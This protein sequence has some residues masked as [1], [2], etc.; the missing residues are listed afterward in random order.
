MSGSQELSRRTLAPA[1]PGINFQTYWFYERTRG[2]YQNEK[3]KLTPAKQKK[4]E[5]MY[6]RGQVIDKT[7]AAKYEVTWG[8]QPHLVSSG[9]QKNFVAFANLVAAKWESAPDSF[10]ELYWKHLVA[11][12]LLFE[13]VRAAIAKADW[14]QKGYLANCVTYTLAKLAYEIGRQSR[15][16]SLDLD[17]IWSTQAV[18]PEVIEECLVIGREVQAVLT[19]E[20]R[21]VQNVTEW[22]KKEACWEAVQAVGHRL[23]EGLDSQLKGAAAVKQGRKDAAATQKIDTGIDA[24]MKVLSMQASEWVGV[25][26]FLRASR[27][28]S[29]TD[30]GILDLV[31]GRRPGVPS[32]TQAKRLLR[33]LQTGR[34]AGQG[35]LGGD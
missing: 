6:P 28:L 35:R 9:A 27:L 8:M 2:S 5:E 30:A 26:E 20:R 19:S 24:Q 17:R 18:S 14:Y 33:L 11:K 1:K 29:P 23:S 25:Q 10:N 32:E 3:N 34:D 7:S 13:T 31:T 21:G 12:A 16:R 4:F 15:G 22:A